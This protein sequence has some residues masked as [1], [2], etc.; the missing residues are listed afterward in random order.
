[1]P[2]AMRTPITTATY[3]KNSVVLN[4]AFVSVARRRVGLWSV[5]LVRPA[6]SSRAGVRTALIANS[7]E[8]ANHGPD[9]LRHSAIRRAS[10]CQRCKKTRGEHRRVLITGY[11]KRRARKH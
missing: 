4:D 9:R 5:L 10:T 3:A 6:T 2:A 7:S 8:V 1:M 11:R